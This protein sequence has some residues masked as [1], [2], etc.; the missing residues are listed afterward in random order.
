[1]ALPEVLLPASPPPSIAGELEA[2][3]HLHKLWEQSDPDAYLASA[4]KNIRSI[5]R[6]FPA[7]IDAKL[8]GALPKLELISSSGVGYDMVDVSAAAAR[9]IVVTNTPDAVTEETADTG[10]AL[11][12]MTVR[13]LGAAERYLRAGLWQKNGD[14]RETEGSLRDRTVGILGL[15]RIGAAI[16]RRLEAARV[17]VAYHSRHRRS[18]VPYRYYDSLLAMAADV[19]TL[20]MAWQVSLPSDR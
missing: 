6:F 14:Y 4:G 10:Y 20:V 2:A 18:D 17:P 3:F 5:A 11:L 7:R 8:I 1:M 19:D 9:Q 13:E 12:T 15:G 16:A